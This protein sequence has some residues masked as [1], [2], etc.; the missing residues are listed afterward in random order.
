MGGPE[1]VV[2]AESGAAAEDGRMEG[3]LYLIRSNRLGLQTSRKRYFVLEDSALRCFKAAPPPST[4]GA[5]LEVPCSNPRPPVLC[6]RLAFFFGG[7]SATFSGFCA[8]L[9]RLCR[10]ESFDC[11]FCSYGDTR[12]CSDFRGSSHPDSHST[13]VPVASS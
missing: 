8:I 12:P 4:S 9:G 6:S 5:T 10:S 3:W 7:I 13:L 2:V 1:P 11:R